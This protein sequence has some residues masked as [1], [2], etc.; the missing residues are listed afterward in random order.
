MSGGEH[1]DVQALQER[2]ASVRGVEMSDSWNALLEFDPTY[3]ESY[4]DFYEASTKDNPIP[5]K[6][7]ELIFVAVDAVTNTLYGPGLEF[8]M[9]RVLALGGTPEE[10]LQ[11]LKM[12]STV[13]IHSCNLGV[14]MLAEIVKEPK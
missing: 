8:H 4:L 7:Q 12:V 2:W 1:L 11:V 6:Y 5:E 3:L 10:I 13:G 9:R 14:P